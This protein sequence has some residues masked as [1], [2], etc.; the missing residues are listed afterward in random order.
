MKINKDRLV[1]L[2]YELYVVNADGSQGDL[3]EATQEEMPL[4]FIYGM[5]LMLPG[6]E[7]ELN[8]LA[9]G[10]KFNFVLSPDE[11]Y[12]Q[13]REDL[14]IDLPREA[15]LIDGKFDSEKV[16]VGAM[17]PMLTDDGQQVQG[18]VVSISDEEVSM[19][20][21][22]PLAGKSLNFVGHIQEVKEPTPEEYQAILQPMM[23]GGCSCGHDHSDGCGGGCGDS[24][25]DGCGCH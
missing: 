24:C 20:F 25:G 21:N 16:Y 7:S 14:K 1:R 12:Q 11:A 17:V 19:D 22:H 9:E 6:F 23:G 5:G 13:P 8:G 10:D 18:L 2:Q 3:I 4:E 15:F